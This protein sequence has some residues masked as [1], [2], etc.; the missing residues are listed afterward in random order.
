MATFDCMS[1]RSSRG[2]CVC[3]AESPLGRRTYSSQGVGSAP[4]SYPSCPRVLETVDRRRTRPTRPTR[5]LEALINPRL[6][7]PQEYVTA[8]SPLLAFQLIRPCW[9]S[10]ARPSATA[11]SL[12]T[13][14]PTRPVSQPAAAHAV[15]MAPYTSCA[16]VAAVQ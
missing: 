5:P 11:Y 7:R 14:Y 4:G 9:K 12:V 16:P 8:V 15:R 13:G 6:G 10:D 3:V 2:C 1:T